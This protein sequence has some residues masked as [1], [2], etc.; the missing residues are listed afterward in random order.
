MAFRSRSGVKVL[1]VSYPHKKNIMQCCNI[2]T[3]S[4]PF[5]PAPKNGQ[6]ALAHA[7]ASTYWY[8]A[9]APPRRKQYLRVSGERESAR[10]AEARR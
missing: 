3:G 10:R 1:A 2:Q 8:I 6:R 7:N 5:Q 9:V 4:Y